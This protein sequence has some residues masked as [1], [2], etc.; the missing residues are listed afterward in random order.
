MAVACA[1]EIQVK[2]RERNADV[3]ESRRIEFRAG[4]FDDGVNLAARLEG[5][6]MPGGIAVSGAV[7]DHIG[8]RLNLAF[9]A[10]P[11]IP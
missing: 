1:A 6:A 2:M 4:I 5:I 11:N 7:R 8:N 10:T 9:G 3:P